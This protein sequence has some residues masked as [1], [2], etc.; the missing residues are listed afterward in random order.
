M[1]EDQEMWGTDASTY[2]FRVPEGK[3]TVNM[4]ETIF[5]EITTEKFPDLLK[6]TKPKFQETKRIPSENLK[7]K[8]KKIHPHASE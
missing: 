1:K 5:E 4:V 7:R 3:N 8:E 2:P 6:E